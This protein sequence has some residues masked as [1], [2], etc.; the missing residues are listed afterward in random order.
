[1]SSVLLLALKAAMKT[2]LVLDNGA[3][4]GIGIRWKGHSSDGQPR[5]LALVVACLQI[6][7][8]LCRCTLMAFFGFLYITFGKM[9]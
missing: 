6:V 9:Q 3:S 5:G 1:M 7:F 2:K 4:G 8:L